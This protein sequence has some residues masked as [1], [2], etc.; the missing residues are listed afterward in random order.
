MKQLFAKSA[1]KA[2]VAKL[3]LA[4]VLAFTIVSCTDEEMVTKP[5]QNKSA[6]I[7]SV[8]EN[9]SMYVSDVDVTE[10]KKGQKA[11]TFKTLIAALQSTNLLTTVVKQD[12][13]LFA[14]SD[15]AFAALGLNSKNIGSLPGLANILTYHVVAGEV[16]SYMLSDGFVT[17]L[18]GAA[19]EVKLNGGVMVNDAN[20]I[21]ADLPAL[22]SVIHVIDKVLLPPTKNL[23]E[24]AQSFNPGQ[25]NILVAA[26]IKADLVN[27]LA[28]GGEFTVF[29]P[30]DAAFAA[31]LVE[32]GYT[33][34]DEIPVDVLTSVLLYH[35]V[36]NR[37]Y[38]SDLETGM[39]T[40]LNGNFSIDVSTLKITD[41]NGRE[42]NLIPSLLNVQAT[43]GVVHVI[44]RVILPAL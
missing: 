7:I 27:T 1:V 5:A 12:L 14:P 28:T 23:V 39:V 34:L 2:N 26:V 42:A 25:F 10:L 30:V 4:V 11:P 29:A 38:S 6:D 32:R 40:T 36:P 31:L 21:R 17:T 24:L 41:V 22:N 18:N 37:V 44:D 19:V 13:T 3:S 8:L 20:V 43:N 9:S 33:S 15:D 35:V 16:Y